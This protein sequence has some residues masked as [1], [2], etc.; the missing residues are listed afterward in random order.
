[1]GPVAI[2]ASEHAD[3]LV[4]VN[5]ITAAIVPTIPALIIRAGKDETPGLNAALDPWL[6]RAIGENR[7][8]SMVNYPDA[9]H[10]FDLYLDTAETRR[11]L[12][13]GLEF[14]GSYLR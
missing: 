1:H 10:A 2:A 7:P 8:I 4:L 11:V 9:P 5:P 6:A 3:C 13:R 14:L 12:R